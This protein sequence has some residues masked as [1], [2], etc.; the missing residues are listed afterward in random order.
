MAGISQRL[1]IPM[2]AVPA[3]SIDAMVPGLAAGRYDIYWDA[4]SETPARQKQVAFVDFIKSSTGWVVT[5]GNPKK[6]ESYET[7]CGITAAIPKGTVHV[8]LIKNA[9]DKCVAAGKP[10]I[11][12][13]IVSDS[14]ASVL[15]VLSGRA[16]LAPTSVARATYIAQTSGGKLTEVT[17]QSDD[18]V[19]NGAAFRKEDPDLAK[20][21]S[22][23]LQSM[24]DDGSYATVLKKYGVGNLAVA[25]A[26][27]RA[28]GS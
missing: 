21:F 27:V 23:A 16:D 14:P 28:G 26:T 5:G 22:A 17:D 9:S 2:E 6:I 12:Q 19:I 24:I 11:V 15:S 1:N 8:T 4:T 7:M 25:T 20:A 13:D 3:G 18:G 10:A